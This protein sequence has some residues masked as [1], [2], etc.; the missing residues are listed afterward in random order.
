MPN[1]NEPTQSQDMAS[2]NPAELHAYREAC[3]REVED[4]K[5]SLAV[6]DKAIADRFCPNPLAALKDGGKEYGTITRPAGEGFET[7]MTVSKTVKWDS[8][9]LMK[10]ASTLPWAD[11]SHLF[12]ITFKM[13]EKMFEGLLPS[14]PAH[15]AI[16][17]ARSV[18][19]GEPKVELKMVEG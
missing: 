12:Q 13:S 7:K 17:A 18:S 11:A 9:A 19:Y 1:P 2:W 3:Y 8:G 16:V 15:A 6:I 10:V 4:A 14:H 5:A